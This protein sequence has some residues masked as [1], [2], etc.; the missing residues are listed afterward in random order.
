MKC[1]GCGHENREGAKFC[2]NATSSEMRRAERERTKG[3][4]EP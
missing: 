1:S 4:G 3:R 2:A